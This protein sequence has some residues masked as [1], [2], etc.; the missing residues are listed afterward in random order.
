[1]QGEHSRTKAGYSVWK[2]VSKETFW[3]FA[4]F[5]Y[6]GDYS[7]PKTTKLQKVVK[8]NGKKKEGTPIFWKGEDIHGNVPG[9][10]EPAT[11]PLEEII[12]AWTRP[13]KTKRRSRQNIL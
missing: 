8:V 11:D 13:K 2:D 5:A 9:I 1:V 4:Q 6:T 3:R 10:P 12:S 7:I